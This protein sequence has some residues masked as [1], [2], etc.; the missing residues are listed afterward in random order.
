MSHTTTIKAVPVRDIGALRSA[1]SD[2]QNEG[3]N[4]ELLQDAQPRMYYSQQHG[5]CDF[6]LHL[7]DCRYDVGFD[8]QE[9]GTYAPV[10][11]LWANE[12]QNQIGTSCPIE[13]DRAQIAIGSLMQNYSK[14]AAINAAVNAGHQV[15]SCIVN[16]QG[17]VELML[18]VN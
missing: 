15:E 11:D 5:K 7:P 6:V 17:E 2:L 3:V 13:A 8:L 12:I 4:C 1:I 16:E 9:D 10:C 18:A 14:H